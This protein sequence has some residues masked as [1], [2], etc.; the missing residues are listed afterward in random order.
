[1]FFEARINEQAKMVKLKIGCVKLVEGLGQKDSYLHRKLV[2][3]VVRH[4]AAFLF[5]RAVSAGMLIAA[6]AVAG[7]AAA[8]ATG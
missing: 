5:W 2:A 1:M 6:G 7:Y 3:Q 8:L 4:Y